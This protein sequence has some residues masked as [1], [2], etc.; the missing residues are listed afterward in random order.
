MPSVLSGTISYYQVLIQYYPILPR[1]LCTL[2]AEPGKGLYQKNGRQAPPV[3]IIGASS[4]LIGRYESGYFLHKIKY[5]YFLR[6][7]LHAGTAGTALV[8]AL[9]AKGGIT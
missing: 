9:V 3:K 4:L 2:A 8:C 1:T 7:L 6:A 5:R